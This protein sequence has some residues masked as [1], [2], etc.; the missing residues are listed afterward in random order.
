MESTPIVTPP[1]QNPKPMPLI[2]SLVVAIIVAL[3]CCLAPG[4]GI[5]VGGGT[6]T[7]GTVQQAIPQWY[8]IFCL[9]G[10]IIPLLVPLII[11]LV[12]RKKNNPTPPVV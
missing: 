1:Q 12:T 6:Y 8:G 10:T 9:C 3:C 11:F 4:I 5:L 2:I 7:I